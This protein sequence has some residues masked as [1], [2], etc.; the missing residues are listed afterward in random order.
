MGEQTRDILAEA[1]Y[2]QA[3]IEALLAAGA[4]S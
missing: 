3:E 1:G 4:A 2:A